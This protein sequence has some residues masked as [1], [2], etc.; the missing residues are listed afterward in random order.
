MA[1]PNNTNKRVFYATQAVAVG[2]N[3]ATSVIDSWSGG[4]VINGS[5][6]LMTAHGI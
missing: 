4:N 5:G 1:R 6:N 3:A 2:D